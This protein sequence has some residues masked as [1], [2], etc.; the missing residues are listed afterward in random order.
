VQSEASSR[1]GKRAWRAAVFFLLAW[2]APAAAAEDARDL[3]G[4]W[5]IKRYSPTIDPGVTAVIFT[6]EGKALYDKT[7]AGLKA[8]SLS[9][10]ARKACAPDGAV[11]IMA[12]PYPFRIDAMPGEVRF[13]FEA[14]NASRTVAMDKPVPA[15]KD[16]PPADMGHAFG[17]WERDTLVVE[18]VGFTDNKTFFDATGLPHSDQLH[19]KE[20]FWKG[21]G[22]KELQ[23]AAIVFDPK[24]YSQ[25]WSQRYVYEKRPDIR[26]MPY[27]CG[28]KNR[29]IS[30]VPGAEAWK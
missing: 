14:N 9:D 11:R 4:V 21:A 29:D 16:V 12:S 30:H 15:I 13:T 2:A 1:L 26:L 19:V 27:V 25:L 24:T 6:P 20:Y 28:G 5:W 10:P 22:G 3:S 18:T 23:Y 17:R 7:L 8:G